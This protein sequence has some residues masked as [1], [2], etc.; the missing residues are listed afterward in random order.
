MSAEHH[1]AAVEEAEPAAPTISEAPVQTCP[2]GGDRLSKE[3]RAP[4]E[5]HG[6]PI[7][8]GAVQEVER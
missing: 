4:A 5:S 2:W 8:I 6:G 1:W 3:L 7:R